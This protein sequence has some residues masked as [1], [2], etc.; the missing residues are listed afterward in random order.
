MPR[1]AHGHSLLPRADHPAR[2]PNV[3]VSFHFPGLHRAQRALW[4]ALA[5]PA[6]GMAVCGV[7]VILRA[8]LDAPPTLTRNPTQAHASPAQSHPQRHRRASSPVRG[9]SSSRLISRPPAYCSCL[10]TRTWPA[11]VLGFTCPGCSFSWKSPPSIL[12][13]PYRFLSITRAMRCES[14]R[15]P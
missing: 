7:R 13:V 10:T 14:N 2:S 6:R 12:Y 1:Q 4:A 9:A 5:S 11:P 8:R 15:M 3:T